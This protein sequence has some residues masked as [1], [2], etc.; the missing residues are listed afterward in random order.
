[1]GQYQSWSKLIKIWLHIW[2]LWLLSIQNSKFNQTSSRADQNLSKC[3][4]NQ[5]KI[6]ENYGNLI[7]ID[8]SVIEFKQMWSTFDQQWSRSDWIRA[9]LNTFALNLISLDCK[10]LEL[11]DNLIKV[12]ERMI[13]RDRDHIEVWSNQIKIDRHSLKSD[14]IW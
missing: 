3:F 14:T 6:S 12:N 13:K 10:W 7:N 4:L 9:K 5:I 2:H 11:G 1:M 8:Q